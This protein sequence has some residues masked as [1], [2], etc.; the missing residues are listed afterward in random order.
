MRTLTPMV[1]NRC[2]LSHPQLF[3]RLQHPI[4][5]HDWAWVLIMDK[6]TWWWMHLHQLS[7]KV[8]A[9]TKERKQHECPLHHTIATNGFSL[10]DGSVVCGYSWES[11]DDDSFSE[12]WQRWR[13]LFGVPRNK[14][15]CILHGFWSRVMKVEACGNQAF[16]PC[17]TYAFLYDKYIFYTS[18]VR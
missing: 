6:Q 7:C 2:D 10:S 1:A 14:P 9:P 18:S 5:C 11:R 13:L 3:H 17:N 15:T 12:Y 16:L 8:L 4:D